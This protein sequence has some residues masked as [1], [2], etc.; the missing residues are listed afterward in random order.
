MRV[1]GVVDLAR[2]VSIILTAN[3]MCSVH[4][5]LPNWDL[6]TVDQILGD[7]C[8]DTECNIFVEVYQHDQQILF[9]CVLLSVWLSDRLYISLQNVNLACKFGYVP[10]QVQFRVHIPWVRYF[11]I[12]FDINAVHFVTLILWPLD[13][14]FG[15][16]SV[17]QT[18]IDTCFWSRLFGCCWGIQSL[19]A[20]PFH[21]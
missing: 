9:K 2:L 12:M 5:S 19:H 11:Q 21:Y 15:W 14:P 4:E 8:F 3:V 1:I 10:S 18:H 13:D 7:V 17:S 16:H 20:F 6:W